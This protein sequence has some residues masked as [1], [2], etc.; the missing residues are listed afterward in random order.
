[1]TVIRR[2]A[3]T[4]YTCAQ[5]FALVN[6]VAA[7]PQ[8]LPWCA[9]ATVLQASATLMRA[10]LGVR[11]GPLALSFTTENRLHPPSG[12]ELALVDGPFEKLRG[13]WQFAPSD[14]GCMVGL[15]LEFEF[16]GRFGGAVLA[17]AFR[18]IADS[19]VDAFVQRARA[20]HGSQVGG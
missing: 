9:E 4:P 6:D 12:I 11:K 20:S 18:P 17:R 3:F 13:Q 1:M 16:G 19:L 5:M 2:R 10:R 7:Y 14:G 8:F 15:E